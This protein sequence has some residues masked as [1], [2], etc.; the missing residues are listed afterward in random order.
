MILQPVSV[1]KIRHY[2][3]ILGLERNSSKG[4]FEEWVHS[5]KDISVIICVGEANMPPTSI[6]AMLSELDEDAQQFMQIISVIN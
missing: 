6:G 4:E 1:L 5:K 3:T 2:P